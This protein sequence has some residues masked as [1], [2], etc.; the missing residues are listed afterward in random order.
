MNLTE[1]KLLLPEI[2]GVLELASDDWAESYC[3]ENG[4][5][6]ICGRDPMS[7]EIYPIATIE[8][9]VTS[10]D[11]QLM[12]KAPLYVRALLML[13]DEAVRAYLQVTHLP[14]SQKHTSKDFAAE[15]SMKCKSDLAFARY[16]TEVHGLE[17]ASSSERVKSRV[18]SILAVQSLAE[19]NNDTE[20][21]ARWLKLRSDFQ[22]WLKR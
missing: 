6:Q 11:R 15:L 3:L 21:A 16:L 4:Q 17:D 10:D 19:L 2:R 8:K 5:S 14:P 12:R 20:A 7:G 22:T 1:A 13:R 18:R 9:A